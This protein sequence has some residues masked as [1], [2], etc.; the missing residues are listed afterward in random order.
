M[1]EEIRQ[2]LIETEQWLRAWATEV[3]ECRHA[4]PAGAMRSRAFAI[5]KLLEEYRDGPGNAT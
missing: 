5:R 4:I 1:N 3:E 2:L